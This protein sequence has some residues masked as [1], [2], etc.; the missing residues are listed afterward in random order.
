MKKLFTILLIVI[1]I[2]A[3]GQTPINLL[4]K[5]EKEIKDA[6]S[7]FSVVSF[8]KSFSETGDPI[9]GYQF[10]FDFST[11][12]NKSNNSIYAALFPLQIENTC[13]NCYYF[14]SDNND[15]EPIVN[16]INESPIFVKIDNV[17]GW[18]NKNKNYDIII[19]QNKNGKGFTLRYSWKFKK[20]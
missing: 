19:E 18:H 12:K 10:D 13:V 9:L 16:N 3:I 2:N 8:E 15:L 20:T 1:S 7:S 6:M 17:F 5:T 4:A 14:Y 11:G